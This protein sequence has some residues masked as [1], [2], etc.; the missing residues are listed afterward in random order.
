MRYNFFHSVFKIFFILNARRNLIL[1]II[2]K[3]R[4]PVGILILLE[5]VFVLF[6]PFFVV[7]SRVIQ[8]ALFG[9][10]LLFTRAGLSWCDKTGAHESTS[11]L[12]IFFRPVMR[13]QARKISDLRPFSLDH[14]VHHINNI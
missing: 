10:L 1:K 4:L 5:P 11:P 2:Q 14:F 8:S 9:R 3:P 7:V 13:A 12:C 6:S